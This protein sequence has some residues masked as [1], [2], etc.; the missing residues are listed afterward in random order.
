MAE[1]K[2][3]VNVYIFEAGECPYCEA[4][5]QYLEGLKNYGKTFEIVR[6][7]LYVDHET[8]AKGKDY[9]LGEK[10]AKEFKKAGF[11]NADYKSTPFVIISD[12]Y[13]AAGYSED[14]ETI[15]AKAYENGDKDIVGCAMNGEKCMIGEHEVD[16]S[17]STGSLGLVFAIL[18]GFALIVVLFFMFSSKQTNEYETDELDKMIKKETKKAKASLLSKAGYELEKG[19]MKAQAEKKKNTKKTTTKNPVKKSTA[20]KTNKK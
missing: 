6:K 16:F 19:R 3:K 7:E 11:E 8:W 2:A 4:E 13:A 1:E 18:A 5:I 20:K 15:I 9:K 17:S 12:I 14:L 10:L